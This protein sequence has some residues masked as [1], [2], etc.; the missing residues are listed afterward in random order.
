M[1]VVFIYSPLD[2]I[3]GYSYFFSL[4]DIFIASLTIH[5]CICTKYTHISM[6]QNDVETVKNTTVDNWD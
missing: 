5:T 2:L 4:S 1:S 6:N 3:H